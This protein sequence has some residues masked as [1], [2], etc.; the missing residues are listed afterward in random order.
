VASLAIV[1][2]IFGLIGIGY[3]SRRFG[4]LS[5][6][7]SEGL[8]EFVFTLAIPCLTFGTLARAT[9]PAAQPWGYWLAY[10][11]A[12]AIVWAIGT[13]VS[14]R[15]FGVP[16]ATSIVAGFLAGQA[17]TVFVG[18]P[19]ILKVYGDEGAV[20]LFLLIAVHLPIV[21]VAATLLIE[22]S[23]A[24]P[25]KILRRLFTN[26]ITLG[27]L[28]GGIGT[29][30]ADY[31]P[32]PVWRVVDLLASAAVPCALVAMGAALQRYGMEAGWPLPSFLSVLKL[33]IHP[34]LV[35]LFATQV[36]DMPRAWAGVA[37]LFA[38]CPCGINAYLF[39][40]HY[41]EGVALA[42]SAI[43]LSTAFAVV[44]TLVWLQV[45]GVG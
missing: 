6:R 24:S 20:P 31:V 34:L 14:R 27:I 29:F 35:L 18:I 22:G 25:T 1:A 23:Q 30:V 17:N 2:P 36:F 7:A 39:A 41:K 11:I 12:V 9:I 16:G 10:F 43:A 33:V 44:T 4:V 5:E 45:L 32:T 21:V 19:L 8:S 37:V 26:P 15:L 28:A 3:V 38:A 40:E 42:S 13:V